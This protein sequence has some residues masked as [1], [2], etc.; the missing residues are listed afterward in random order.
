MHIL[1][2]SHPLTSAQVDAISAQVGQ[3]VTSLRDVKTQFDVNA[4]FQE[5]V[6]ALLEGLDISSTDWQSQAWLILLPSLNYAAAVM[7]A[8]LHGRMGH[9]PTI[10]RLRP[11]VG[12]L[13]TEFEL[14]EVINLEGVRQIARTRR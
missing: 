6:I 8:E 11:K 4:P 9:F 14:A 2:F 3:S 5:Q 7:L 12:A 1:N 10:A 13:V